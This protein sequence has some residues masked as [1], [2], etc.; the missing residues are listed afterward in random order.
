[1][2]YDMGMN[3]RGWPNPFVNALE[4]NTHSGF[5]LSQ[6]R[7]NVQ[8]PLDSSTRAFASFNASNLDLQDLYVTWRWRNWNVTFG[9]FRG[10]G[11]RS[12]VLEDEFDRTAITAPYY[13]R[14]WSAAQRRI[15]GRDLGLQVEA[16]HGDGLFTHRL[17]VRNATYQFARVEDP[18]YDQGAPTQVLGFSYAWDFRLPENNQVGGHVEALADQ[19]WD[20]F[21][22]P[23]DF[24]HV[25]DWF[26]TNPM[27]GASLYHAWSQD[28]W[29]WNSEAY[30]RLNRRERNAVDSSASQSWAVMTEIHKRVSAQWTPF[31]RYEFFDPSDGTYSNDNV[32]LITV[33]AQ[34]HPAPQRQPNWTLTPEYVLVREEGLAALL[35]N[36]AWY[37]QSQ[38]TF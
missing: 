32:H 3:G 31:F 13:A 7:L 26:R 21:V 24:W 23:R 6:A 18:S 29:T 25:D 5:Y 9:K 12:M 34:W 15:N 17:F 36:D 19:K 27:I 1:M 2:G 28:G 38:W 20:E 4:N 37:L 33:G 11:L 22:G 10:A 8:M 14:T 30:L 35:A 16:S